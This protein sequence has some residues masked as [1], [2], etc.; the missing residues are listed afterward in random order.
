[1][2]LVAGAEGLEPP[3][4][5]LENRCSI[6]LSY[7]PNKA[8]INGLFRLKGKELIVLNLIYFN[9]LKYN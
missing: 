1:M 8:C 2:A 5:G 3:T 6:Q 7:T 4:H 9:L